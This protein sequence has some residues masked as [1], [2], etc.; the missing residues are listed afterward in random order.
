MVRPIIEVSGGK[1]FYGTRE[2]IYD[3]PLETENQKKDFATDLISSLKTIN[4]T[5]SDYLC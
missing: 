1:M 3:I 5:F 2:A 4:T